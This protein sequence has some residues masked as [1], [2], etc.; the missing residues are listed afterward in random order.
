ME[1]QNQ[2]IRGGDSIPPGTFRGGDSIP[3]GTFH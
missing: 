3:A 1:K 2:N